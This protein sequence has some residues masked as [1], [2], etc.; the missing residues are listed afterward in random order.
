MKIIVT[1]AYGPSQEFDSLREAGHEV[2][3]GRPM[4]QPGRQPYTKEEL[5][6][7]C[8]DAD[9]IMASH[10]DT[11][12]RPVLEGAEQLRLVVLPFVAM[13]KIDVAAA[14]ELGIIVA[15]SPAPQQ[16][17]GAAEATIGLMVTLLKRIKRNEAKLR[18]G[19]WAQRVDR[20]SL[21]AG[22]TIGLVGLGRA[23]TQVARRLQ[24][25]DARLLAVDPYVSPE[26]ARPLG[27]ALVTLAALLAESDVVSLHVAL[28]SKTRGMIGEK[29]LRAMKRTAF[30]IN[31]ARGELVDEDALCRAIEENWIAGAALDTFGQEPLPMESRL[32]ALD[33][34]RVVLTPHNVGQTEAGRVAS[35][36]LA[37]EATLTALKGEVPTHS[38]NAQAVTLWRQRFGGTKAGGPRRP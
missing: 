1:G 9:V 37:L 8:R 28:T 15:N 30:L 24:G 7:W 29:E 21:L 33:P 26:K 35:L 27:V 12:S 6:D 3:L 4:D 32:R 25:W 14:T 18:R 10:L 22:K 19:G 2:V 38:V 34:E 23:A 36:K 13:D 17:V 16:F 20:G 11:I 31:T 5:V